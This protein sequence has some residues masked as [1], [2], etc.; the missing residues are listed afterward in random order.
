M[1]SKYIVI[2]SL[3]F[4][5][6]MLWVESIKPQ[7]ILKPS[8]GRNSELLEKK[9]QSLEAGDL[10]CCSGSPEIYTQ[11]NKQTYKQI[12]QNKKKQIYIQ[13]NL[14]VEGQ[15]YF[16]LEL[17]NYSNSIINLLVVFTDVQG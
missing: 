1:N 10:T 13:S 16:I 5:T 14:F 11:Q 15:Q 6:V 9:N 3:V 17:S 12:R 2:Q 8:F 4:G 7:F